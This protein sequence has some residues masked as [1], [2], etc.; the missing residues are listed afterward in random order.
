MRASGRSAA[1]IIVLAS[2]GDAPTGSARA[3]GAGAEAATERPVG[4]LKADVKRLSKNVTAAFFTDDVLI[5][6]D[7]GVLNPSK[8]C[9]ALGTRRIGSRLTRNIAN[10]PNPQLIP[11]IEAIIATIIDRRF[12]SIRPRKTLAGCRNCT[13]QQ[14]RYRRELNFRIRAED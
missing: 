3:V 7:S 6:M 5:T 11:R 10:R 4:G 13:H 2:G 14:F 9:A 1:P 12:G 8:D